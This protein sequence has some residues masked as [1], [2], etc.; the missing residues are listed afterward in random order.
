MASAICVCPARRSGHSSCSGCP[1]SGHDGWRS[2]AINRFS[3]F[4]KILKG[5][6]GF[7]RAM[8]T[9]I[10]GFVRAMANVSID[11]TQLHGCGLISASV[12]FCDASA[13]KR[14]DFITTRC[15]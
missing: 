14:R 15:D 3:P 9:M 10:K 5:I 7:N 11:V 4:V 2:D 1:E 12:N 13:S 6:M 8:A